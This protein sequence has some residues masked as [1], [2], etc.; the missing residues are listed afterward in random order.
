[1]HVAHG[2][3]GDQIAVEQRRAGE[4]QAAAADDAGLAG[5]R[6]RVR[7]RR[8]LMGFLALVAGQRAG[9]RIEQQILAMLPH[10]LRQVVVAQRGREL[11]QHSGCFAWHVMTSACVVV[12]VGAILRRNRAL[13]TLAP[14]I[15]HDLQ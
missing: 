13:A 15:A 3:G 10:A 7:Q 8:E 5:L 1:M 2:G 9:E 6:E 4:R 12:V 11:R 14:I